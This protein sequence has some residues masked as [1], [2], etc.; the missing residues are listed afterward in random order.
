MKRKVKFYCKKHSDLAH[1][2]KATTS[3]YTHN[4]RCN[5]KNCIE[6]NTM[7]HIYI[8]KNGNT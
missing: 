3:G 6:I 4:K 8:K 1:N 2:Y 7:R 5:Y